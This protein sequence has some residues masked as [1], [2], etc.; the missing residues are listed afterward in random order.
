MF[1]PDLTLYVNVPSLRLPRRCNIHCDKGN[2]RERITQ[3]TS[4]PFYSYEKRAETSGNCIRCFTHTL[5]VGKKSTLTRASARRGRNQ[6]RQAH[7]AGRLIWQV[8]WQGS[9]ARWIDLPISIA[10]IYM[11]GPNTT[12][13]H[14]KTGGTWQ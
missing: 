3:R 10:N 4:L 2:F 1:P 14:N 5:L 6:S 11:V 13:I 8:G 9:Q 12:N 7:K